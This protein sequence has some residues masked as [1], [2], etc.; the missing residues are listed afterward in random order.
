[1]IQE[2]KWN[3][4]IALTDQMKRFTTRLPKAIK[5]YIIVLFMKGLIALNQ[6]WISIKKSHNTN[7]IFSDQS[8]GLIGF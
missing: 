3:K 2:A 4:T 6:I 1:L 8:S 5:N 7:L